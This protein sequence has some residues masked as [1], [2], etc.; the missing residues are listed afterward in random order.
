MQL[1]TD[2]DLVVHLLSLLSRLH[3]PSA[4]SQIVPLRYVQLFS[5][6]LWTDHP[7]TTL[8]VTD[9]CHYSGNVTAFCLWNTSSVSFACVHRLLVAVW[10]FAALVSLTEFCVL[11]PTCVLI[12]C[13]AFPCFPPCIYPAVEKKRI[14]T[15]LCPTVNWVSWPN[16]TTLKHPPILPV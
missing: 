15:E 10:R 1:N 8:P 11:K 6:S 16:I 3:S 9:S 7:L 2:Y 14:G 5:T 4:L 12:K 13:G